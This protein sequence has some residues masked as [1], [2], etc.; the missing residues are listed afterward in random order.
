MDNYIKM[1]LIVFEYSG[2]IQKN[3]NLLLM[4]SISNYIKSKYKD[5]KVNQILVSLKSANCKDN[6]ENIALLI[7]N[8]NIFSKE[9]GI[10]I[11][12]IDYKPETYEV[13]RTLSKNTLVKL[14][15][16]F[17][18]AR[19]FFIPNSY[20]KNSLVLICDSDEE[21]AKKLSL[22]L[23]AYDNFSITVNHSSS[24]EKIPDIKK[25]QIVVTKS[26]YNLDLEK[27]NGVTLLH[28]SK[29]LI[30]VL[31]LFMESAVT[32][33]ETITALEAKKI[34]HKVGF[35]EKDLPAG[36]YV[37]SIM[38]FRGDLM[39]SFVLIFS[40][41]NAFAAIE[42]FLQEELSKNDIEALKDGIGE[43]CNIITGSTKITLSK[44]NIN[45]LFEIPLTFTSLRQLLNE[46]G[47]DNGII[48][49]MRLDQKPFYMFITK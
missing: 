46:I 15:N 29:K 22:H 10:A 24:P 31:P 14:F 3:Q 49:N 37:F 26:S 11:A 16:N 41:E 17:N 43:L 6:Y 40:K 34:S 4:N 20:K 9:N 5:D 38:K 23:S 2:S 48:I 45:I 19:L 18:I 36:N 7:K 35:L 8:L 42:A 25:Y 1:G 13:L 44:Q 33:L 21:N 30:G 39:G 47:N 27:N 28:L 12:L 32:S